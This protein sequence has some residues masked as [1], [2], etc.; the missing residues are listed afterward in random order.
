[1]EYN[2][3]G[4]EVIIPME[5]RNEGLGATPENPGVDR[6]DNG[7]DS[8]QDDAPSKGG[9]T[10]LP[11]GED[12]NDVVSISSESMVTVESSDHDNIDIPSAEEVPHELEELVDES[13]DDEQANSI[14]NLGVTA[15]N[16]LADG[17][18]RR[19]RLPNINPAEGYNLTTSEG[20]QS[21][22]VLEVVVHYLNVL[23]TFVNSVDSYAHARNL[24]QHTAD[25]LLL[26]QLSMKAGIKAFGQQGVDAVVEEMRQFHYREIV[27]PI[28]PT[29]ITPEVRARALGYLMFLKQNRNG[30]IKGRGCA[31]GLPERVYKSKLETS[32]PTVCTESV[33]IGC[34][35]DAKEGRDVA[36]VDIPCAFL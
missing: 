14:I 5:G 8:V 26:T 25:H 12:V 1:M 24:M 27:S 20:E 11:P 21:D 16:I 18:R 7:A 9:V 6:D 31:D 23:A 22:D 2:D 17:T 19:Q 30:D 3:L 29:E 13:A 4:D 34:A 15:E 10:Q 33:F 35:M 36:H 32:S 28:N